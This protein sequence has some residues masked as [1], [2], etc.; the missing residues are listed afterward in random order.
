M[1]I[2]VHPQDYV[3]GK[4]ACFRNM[5][6]RNPQLG[7][8]GIG[9]TEYQFVM[10]SYALVNFSDCEV[11]LYCREGSNIY[12]DGVKVHTYRDNS[13]LIE[14]VKA[15]GNDIFILIASEE[16]DSVDIYNRARDAG[17]NI[18]AWVHN[19]MGAKLLRIL[20]TN[21]AVKRI[22]MVSHE[23][24]DHYLD[25]PAIAKSAYIYCMCD[26]KRFKLRE[27]PQE[28]S[29]TYT[30]GLYKL[31]GFHVLASMWKDILTEV[32]RAKLYVVGSGRLYVKDAKLGSYGL[33]DEEY[34]PMFMKY[35]TDESGKIIPSVKF[36]GTLGAEKSEI[37]YKTT[38]GVVNPTG[39]TENLA[40]SAV[41]MEAC[42]VP[43]VTRAVSGL[44]EA[45]HHGETGFLGYNLEEIKKYI[46][47]LLKD[48]ELNLRLGR[49]AKDHAEKTFSPEVV[50]KQWLKLFDDVLDNRPC[51][52]IPPTL[53]NTGH[54]RLKIFNR[55]LRTH[56]IPT[57]P[58]VT[59]IS[60]VK[61]TARKLLPWPYAVIKKILGRP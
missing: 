52:Y 24:Y 53:H 46:I 34:E 59:L 55:W 7:N 42:G 4:G 15:D 25:H 54:K 31:K 32:P 51:E 36:L 6:L 20:D 58:V 38:V 48:K 19:F 60:V 3:A 49:N 29:V 44:F 14:Q 23:N 47:L 16:P 2:A 9:G 35:L 21:Q 10:L 22:V 12:P 11:N 39:L 28:P 8:P 45:V 61:D 43:V 37:Y 17:I 56:H 41:D 40:M 13:E 27:Y 18:I 5:D 57:I 50:V 33:A 30:G 1:K 26:G